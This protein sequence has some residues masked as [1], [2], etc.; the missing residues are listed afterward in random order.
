VSQVIFRLLIGLIQTFIIVLI[1]RLAFGV[2][3]AGSWAF[4]FAVVV[5]GTTSFLSLGYIVASFAK[6]EQV[7]EPMIQVVSM[8]MMFLS[9]VFFPVDM[10]PGFIQPLIKLLPLTYLNDALRQIANQGHSIESTFADLAILVVWL[11]VGLTVSF[12][13]FRWE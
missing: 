12:K 3:M 10:M 2:Q 6:S 9:G 7:A 1:G 4:L 13:T 11:A 8:P 5:V